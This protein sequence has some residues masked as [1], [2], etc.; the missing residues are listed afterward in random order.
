MDVDE[1][2]EGKEQMQRVTMAGV[3]PQGKDE[4]SVW[5]WEGEDGAEKRV[6]KVRS[7]QPECCSPGDAS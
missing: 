1:E 5:V 7:Y 6:I 2:E 3:V 4:A